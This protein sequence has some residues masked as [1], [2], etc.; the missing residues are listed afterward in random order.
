MRIELSDPNGRYMSIDSRDPETL[1][2]WIVEKLTDAPV[3]DTVLHEYGYRLRAWPSWSADGQKDWVGD[4]IITPV[5]T[6]R[7]LVGGLVDYLDRWEA[8]NGKTD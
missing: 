1:G 4:L 3:D 6:P 8:H 2:R 7:E 5:R